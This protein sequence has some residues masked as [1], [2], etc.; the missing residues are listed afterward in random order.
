MSLNI[1]K[2]ILLNILTKLNVFNKNNNT[3]YV[4][5]YLVIKK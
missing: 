4:E 5:K 3:I 2:N 1:K